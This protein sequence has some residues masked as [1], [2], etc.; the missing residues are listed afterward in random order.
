MSQSTVRRPTGDGR[1]A[2]DDPHGEDGRD[3]PAAV[4]AARVERDGRGVSSSGAPP[5]LRAAWRALAAVGRALLGVAG[6]LSEG[7]LYWLIAAWR[8]VQR[9][10]D[11]V[12]RRVVPFLSGEPGRVR[13][14][15]VPAGH[16]DEADGAVARPPLTTTR[17]PSSPSSPAPWHPRVGPWRPWRSRRPAGH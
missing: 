10:V 13:L 5:A 15:R 17:R 6:A 7:T 2:R 12:E 14:V 16:R 3:A 9:R 11:R 8:A 4:A 1:D